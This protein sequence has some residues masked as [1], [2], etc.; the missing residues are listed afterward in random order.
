MPAGLSNAQTDKLGERLKQGDPSDSDLHL[1]DEFRQSFAD[2]YQVTIAAL[3]IGIGLQPTGR[4]AK[5]TMSII[6]KLRRESIRLTQMQDVAG[7]RV[8]VADIAAQ[9]KVVEAL[10]KEFGKVAIVDRRKWPS[11]GYRAIHAIAKQSGKPIEIQVRTML[12]HTWAEFSEKCAD[13]FDPGIKYGVGPKEVIDL[14][15]KASQLLMEL[16]AAELILSPYLEGLKKA[17]TLELEARIS[18]TAKELQAKKDQIRGILEQG[19][20]AISGLQ[21]AK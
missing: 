9:E 5:S 14:L 2:A 18:D 10:Q 3:R 6:D 15:Q 7:C 20:T 1:L 19:I 17:P 8:V 4:S 21:G 11:H 16:E 12:Q 13:I